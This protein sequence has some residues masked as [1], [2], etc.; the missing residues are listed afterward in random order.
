MRQRGAD[1]RG[2]QT[3]PNAPSEEAMAR[4]FSKWEVYWRVSDGQ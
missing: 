4:E 2:Y 3:V 1:K